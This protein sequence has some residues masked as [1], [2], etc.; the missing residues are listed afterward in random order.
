MKLSCPNCKSS[1]N[2]K[3]ILYG[4]PSDDFDHEKFEVGGCVPSDATVR[5]TKCEWDDAD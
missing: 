2:L 1:E 4:M 5:C 3:K